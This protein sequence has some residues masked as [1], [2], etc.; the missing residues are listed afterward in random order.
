[1][2]EPAG[3]PAWQRLL[4][5]DFSFITRIGTYASTGGFPPDKVTEIRSKVGKFLDSIRGYKSAYYR[6]FIKVP[7]DLPLLNAWSRS[8]VYPTLRDQLRRATGTNLTI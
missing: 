1:M 7:R 3:P 2:C 5:I 6:P 4:A 8:V